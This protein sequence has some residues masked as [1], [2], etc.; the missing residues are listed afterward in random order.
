MGRK[1]AGRREGLNISPGDLLNNR[2]DHH[3]DRRVARSVRSSGYRPCYRAASAWYSTSS[4]AS[5]RLASLCLVKHVPWGSLG[6]STTLPSRHRTLVNIVRPPLLFSQLCSNSLRHRSLEIRYSSL[7][8]GRVQTGLFLTEA[9]RGGVPLPPRRGDRNERLHE[10]PWVRSPLLVRACHE[11]LATS[12]RRSVL[13]R[14]LT[15]G[16]D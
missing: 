2:G 16:R 6:R 10:I 1:W 7:L 11:C 5:H 14:A 4:S 13:R 3:T 15:N 8:S 12:S 9:K